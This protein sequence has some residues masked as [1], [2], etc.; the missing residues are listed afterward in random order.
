MAWFGF[1][2]FILIAFVVWTLGE[3]FTIYGAAPGRIRA[4]LSAD[5]RGTLYVQA[6]IVRV[7]WTESYSSSEDGV[8][9]ATDLFDRSRP[10]DAEVTPRRQDVKP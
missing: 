2:L 4:A 8:F 6:R 9:E 7:S 1:G 10:H 3:L 5:V